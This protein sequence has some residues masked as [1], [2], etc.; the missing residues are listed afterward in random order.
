MKTF[1]K[2]KIIDVKK[3]KS[4]NEAVIRDALAGNPDLLDLGTSKL[5]L[6]EKERNEG[7][8]GRLDLLFADEDNK[9]MYETELQLGA[10][11]ESH[12]VRCL[13]YW[14][15]EQ[16]QSPGYQHVAILIA[17]NVNSRFKN[18]LALL[19]KYFPLIV[20]ELTAFEMPGDRF[21]FSVTKVFATV[22]KRQ[23]S[24]S[25]DI[26]VDTNRQYWIEKFSNEENLQLLER[27]VS[28]LSGDFPG[29]VPNYKA[30]EI[31]LIRNGSVNNFVTF[32]PGQKYVSVRPR[33]SE[34]EKAAA[35]FE[36]FGVNPG[37][38]SSVPR[39]SFAVNHENFEELKPLIMELAHMA[40]EE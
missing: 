22:S 23:S 40:Y 37:Y 39:Y 10:I 36:K 20:Y 27:I 8:F 15:C 4:I 3:C 28:F 26:E 32:L 30:R 31:G 5:R 24:A 17:E 33:M 35:L 21:S 13:E 7:D 12:I 14:D 6:V 29:Y 19:H 34:S 1:E 11:D 16:T 38:A 18:V 2:V 9:I 25:N